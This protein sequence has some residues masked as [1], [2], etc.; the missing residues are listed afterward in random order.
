[1]NESEW[2]AQMGSYPAGYF[3]GGA[4]Q[5]QDYTYY[6]EGSREQGESFGSAE[7]TAGQQDMRVFPFYRPPFFPFPYYQPFYPY[8]GFYGGYGGYGG[9]PYYHRPYW[10]YGHHWY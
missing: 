9:F 1:M 4:N 5:P 2:Q 10:H 8:G 7:E 6:Q 3:Q